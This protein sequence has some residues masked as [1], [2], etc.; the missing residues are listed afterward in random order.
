LSWSTTGKA[1]GSYQVAVWVRDA[2]SPGVFSNSFG[3]WDA[4]TSNQYTLK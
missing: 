1:P 4:F 2:G 3:T